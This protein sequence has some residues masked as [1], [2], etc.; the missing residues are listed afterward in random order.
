[1][2]S[3]QFDRELEDRLVRY[4]K[5]DT[6]A[7]EKS[8]TSPSTAIQFD[9]LNLPRR[10][11]KLDE[12]QA[13][14]AVG[15]IELGRAWSQ[16]LSRRSDGATRASD[17]AAHD[18]QVTLNP[19]GRK[20]PTICWRCNNHNEF[21]VDSLPRP[22]CTAGTGQETVDEWMLAGSGRTCRSDAPERQ[23]H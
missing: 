21:S 22:S 15:Q 14:A 2:P 17:A 9:L 12:S 11:L 16:A 10:P 18:N 8:T 20:W 4:C 23:Y 3:T 7:D 6:Q 13:A 19:F 5:I 1:M